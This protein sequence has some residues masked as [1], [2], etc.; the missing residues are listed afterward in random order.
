ML[1]SQILDDAPH[2]ALFASSFRHAILPSFARTNSTRITPHLQRTTVLASQPKTASVGGD[3][4]VLIG[5]D[6]GL[7]TKNFA[8]AVHRDHIPDDRKIKHPTVAFRSQ[9]TAI[10][11]CAARRLTIATWFVI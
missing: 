8:Q 3:A 1:P 6:Y 10:L 5:T 11:S 7:E 9:S 4:L 2:G